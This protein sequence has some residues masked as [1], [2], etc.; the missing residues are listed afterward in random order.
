ML[1][2]TKE[3]MQDLNNNIQLQTVEKIDD[4]KND[5]QDQ[6]AILKEQV[7]HTTTAVKDELSNVSSMI[8][9]TPNG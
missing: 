4:L 8:E 1:N 6:L 2:E 3:M 9:R 7:N 5:I